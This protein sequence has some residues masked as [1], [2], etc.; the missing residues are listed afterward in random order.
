MIKVE[1]TIKEFKDSEPWRRMKLVAV[2]RVGD[3]VSINTDE[4]GTTVGRFVRV[5]RVV[6][7][8]DPHCGDGQD[9]VV[10]HV[11]LVPKDEAASLGLA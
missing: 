10:L 9:D 3:L 8:A 7:V 6:F 2:P 1:M 4:S 11:T 5:E